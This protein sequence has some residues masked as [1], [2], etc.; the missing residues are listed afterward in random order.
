MIVQIEGTDY[1]KI[2]KILKD[3]GVDCIIHE[4]VYKAVCYEEIETTLDNEYFEDDEIKESID[5]L[6]NELYNSKG[7][8]HAFQRLSE[9]AADIVS[10]I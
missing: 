10:E 3:N 8:E 2:R 7:A 1:E 6:T 5:D 9:E 4:N